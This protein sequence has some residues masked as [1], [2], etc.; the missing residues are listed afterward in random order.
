MEKVGAKGSF[1]RQDEVKSDL[2]KD[3][4]ESLLGNESSFDEPLEIHQDIES[5]HRVHREVDLSRDQDE[6]DEP[7]N[8]FSFK[9]TENDSVTVRHDNIMT[10]T[11]AGSARNIRPHPAMVSQMTNHHYGFAIRFVVEASRTD[12][13]D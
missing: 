2:S 10:D 1:E 8:F 9:E 7:R 4:G 5:G 6:D 12:P 3:K 13:D 11:K